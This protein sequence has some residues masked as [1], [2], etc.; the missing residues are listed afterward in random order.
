M[1]G[2]IFGI[3]IIRG[4]VRSST[5]RPHY[6]LVRVVEGKVISEEK[7]V[8]LYR[9]QRYIENERPKILAV[10]SIQEISKDTKELYEFLRVLPSETKLVQVTGDGAR[11]ETLPRVAA[12]YNIR[13][14]KTNPMDEARASALITSLGGGFE[15]L[16]FEEVTDI[17]VS[18]YRS[19][20]RGGWSQNRY[21]RKVHGAVRAHTRAIEDSLTKAGLAYSLS[22]RRAFGG[23][24]RAVFTV[25]APKSKI[26]VS[27]SKGGDTQIRVLERKKER[28]EFQPLTK[29]PVYLIVGIDPG[30]TIG[31]AA[32]DLEGNLVYLKSTRLFSAADLIFE[33]AK[34]GHPVI[35]ASDKAEMPFGVEKIRRAFSAASWTPKKDI[36]IKEKYQITEGK[37]FKN[38][39]ERDSLAAALYAYKSYKNKFDSILKRA[40]PGVLVDEIFVRVIKGL[41]LEQALSE[42]LEK[43]ESQSEESTGKISEPILFDERD[44]RIARQEEELRRLRALAGE[45]SLESTQKDKTIAALNKKLSEEREKTHTEILLSSEVSERDKELSQVKKALRKEERRCK[46]LRIKLERMKHY[47]TLQAGEG[48]SALKVLPLFSRDAIRSLDDEMGVLKEDILYVLKIDGWGKTALRDIF[49]A[50]VSAVILPRHVYEKAKEQHLL[51]EFREINTPLLS[52][53]DLSPRVRG[54]IGVV[55]TKALLSALTEWERTQEVYLKRKKA[56]EIDV[57]VKEYQVERVRDVLVQGIDPTTFVPEKFLR[58]PEP[59]EKP[60][61]KSIEKPKEVHEPKPPRQDEPKPKPESDLISSVLSEYRKERQK[62]VKGDENG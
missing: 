4:S 44:E 54:K 6:A 60:K 62:S 3:D 34:L 49:D 24:S 57:M 31:V 56:G 13:I 47:I 51:D 15:V 45:L 39:H 27:S 40:P 1:K 17:T 33:I 41:S 32:L 58:N 26:P 20:G 2:L 37:D 18:R 59:K 5:Q 30:T 10:D 46:N 22:V 50:G 11:M 43:E 16:A 8:T 21:I 36:L 52:G 19:L 35:V 23:E 42:I 7:E 53:A 25:F 55:D 9:L 29:K 48:C 12:K 38:D 28:I 61:P 14:D